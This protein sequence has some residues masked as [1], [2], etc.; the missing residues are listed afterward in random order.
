[1]S[2]EVFLVCHQCGAKMTAKRKKPCIV[3]VGFDFGAPVFC[4]TKC[5]HVYDCTNL[6]V[7]KFRGLEAQLNIGR[8]VSKA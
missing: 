1:M 8:K 4:S 3:N 6:T 2:E 5:A 7:S